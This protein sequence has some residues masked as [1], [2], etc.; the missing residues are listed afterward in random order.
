M[1]SLNSS[2]IYIFDV[3][4]DPRAPRIHKVSDKES[5]TSEGLWYRLGDLD[6]AG[7]Q[8]NLRSFL[9]EATAPCIS[10]SFKAINVSNHDS[11]MLTAAI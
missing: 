2:R 3:E 6:L 5:G 9:G 1:P 11:C 4:A 7:E 8:C 10:S